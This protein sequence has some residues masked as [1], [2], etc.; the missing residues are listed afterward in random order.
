MDT[1]RCRFF[2]D[3]DQRELCPLVKAAGA[4]PVLMVPLPEGLFDQIWAAAAEQ[5]LREAR[6]V[7]DSLGGAELC[8]VLPAGELLLE[9]YGELPFA[10]GV[11]HYS[12]AAWVAKNAGADSI[13]IHRAGTLLQA[14]AG[15]LGARIPGLPV[16]VTMEITGE[17]EGLAGGG[18]ILAAFITLQELGVAAFGFCAAVTGIILSALEEVAPYPRVPLMAL[19]RDLTGELPTPEIRELFA[20]RTARLAELGAGW[21]G[22]L[23]AGA[24][25]VEAAARA[26][27]V[28]EPS[29]V[30]RVDYR[31][32]EEI[33]A[34]GERQV[35]YLDGG[36]EFSEPILCESD[37]ADEIIRLEHQG[38]EA[39]CIQPETADDGYNVSLNNANL[40]MLPVVFLCDDED[41][42]DS[43]LFFYNGRAMVDSRSI[44]P[45]ERLREV[46]DRYGA[47]VV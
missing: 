40:T 26:L 22:V 20:A 17:G 16:Y 10:R 41:A 21:Q 42:L 34:A 38:E 28:T 27:A 14:R 11:A 25:E 46:A 6:Q 43:A 7:L 19:T 13:L 47:V 36:I 15:V 18:D 23:G 30:P 4:E 9:P 2:L 24:P 1:H 3:Y 31:G 29:P 8:A 35:F 5:R 33:W 12:A 39:I 32:E 45:E 37:M 44:L